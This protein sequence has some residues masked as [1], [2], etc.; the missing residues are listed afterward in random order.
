MLTTGAVESRTTTSRSQT[1][2]RRVLR[3]MFER[4]DSALTAQVDVTPA[5]TYELCVVP[6]WDVS[7]AVVEPFGRPLD[8]FQ[9]HAEIARQLRD[10][11]WTRVY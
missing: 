11:G 4:R 7:R 1:E 2:R 9:R 5:G 10:G 8:A 3:W 6:H